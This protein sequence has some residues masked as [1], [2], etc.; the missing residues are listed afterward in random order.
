MAKIVIEETKLNKVRALGYKGGSRLED[1]MVRLNEK[2][3]KTGKKHVNGRTWW[4]DFKNKAEARGVSF[5]D[6][7]LEELGKELKNGG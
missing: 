1:L 2:M 7:V 3:Q 6:A 4:I 5:E